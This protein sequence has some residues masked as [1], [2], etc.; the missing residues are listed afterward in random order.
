MPN[1]AQT[2]K[3]EISHVARKE[4]REDIAALRKAVVAHR[5]EM[6]SLKRTVKELGTQLRLTQKA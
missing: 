1:L 4:V 2:F 5:S 6:A 3:Q